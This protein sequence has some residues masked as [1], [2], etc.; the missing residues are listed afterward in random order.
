MS[1]NFCQ[2]ICVY[3][4]LN[5]HECQKYLYNRAYLIYN[6]STVGGDCHE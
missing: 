5:K 1:S 6:I 4:I 3:K 2:Q